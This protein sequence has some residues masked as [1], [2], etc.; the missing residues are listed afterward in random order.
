MGLCFFSSVHYFTSHV[1]VPL[2]YMSLFSYLLI[3]CYWYLLRE[4]SFHELKGWLFPEIIRRIK[5]RSMRAK[6][7]TY[8][9]SGTPGTTSC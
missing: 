2:C 5:S 4:I 8:I 9:S 1:S 3:Q 6:M 7:Y